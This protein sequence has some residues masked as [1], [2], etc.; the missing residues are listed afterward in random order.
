MLQFGFFRLYA[1]EFDF[2]NN[3]VS[4]R[5]GKYLNK[6]HMHWAASGKTDRNWVSACTRRG[7][8][9]CAHRAGR[10]NDGL[11]QICVEDPFEVTHNLGRVCDRDALY[12]IR[13]E[14]MR[15]YDCLAKHMDPSS[16]FTPWTGEWREDRGKPKE[17]SASGDSAV[18][19]AA[20][21]REK[22]KRGARS[23]RGRS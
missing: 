12:A 5:T 15:G 6:K 23:Q 10:A 7:L 14:F 19:A 18:D 17:D 16:L 20:A 1:H 21:P 8:N 3:V 22:P 2:Q 4:V 9:D 13:G 11:S